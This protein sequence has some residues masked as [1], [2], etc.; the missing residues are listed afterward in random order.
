MRDTPTIAPQWGR[1]RRQKHEHQKRVICFLKFT[2]I[3]CLCVCL[4][5]CRVVSAWVI[6]HRGSK[7]HST[8]DF[9]IPCGRE[10]GYRPAA[11][12]PSDNSAWGRQQ[13]DDNVVLQS[14]TSSTSSEVAAQTQRGSTGK[15]ENEIDDSN[16]KIQQ[17]LFQI[18]PA[19]M[20]DMGRASKILSDGFFK[21]KTNVFTYQ[22]ERLITYLSLESTFPKPNSYHE[23]FVACCA[24][25]GTVWGMVEVDGR[26]NS[27]RTKTASATPTLKTN[28]NTSRDDDGPYMC[29]LAVDD[30]RQRLGIATALVAECERQV[31]EWHDVTMQQQQNPQPDGQ[32]SQPLLHVRDDD[33]MAVGDVTTCSNKK[34]V[35]GS[36]CLKVR[37]SNEPAIQLYTKLGY[38]LVLEEMEEKTGE[39]VLLLRK[40]LPSSVG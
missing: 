9:S 35:L 8:C 14:T 30:Q 3:L 36:L 40:K 38:R 39:T 5:C 11:P 23:I 6:L 24:Q 26:P 21:H 15:E 12:L 20:V 13:P 4:L 34:G 31:Q 19:L 25:T 18:R 27:N 29:N 1:M 2:S 28:N 37:V 32:G 17:R 33:G 7:L 16:E 22:W 10:T